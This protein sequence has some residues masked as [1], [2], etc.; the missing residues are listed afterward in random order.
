MEAGGGDRKEVN[1]AY[2]DKDS[3]RNIVHSLRDLGCPA[4]G[5]KRGP[6]CAA[7]PRGETRMLVPGGSS[8]SNSKAGAALA[9]K[10]IRR[11]AS[12][13]MTRSMTFATS[14]R[15]P[16]ACHVWRRAGKRS[17]RGFASN[18]EPG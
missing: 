1:R 8:A 11:S 4:N 13:R 5:G 9:A 12:R 3:N 10:R 6:P 15:R 16:E 2:F 17:P 14:S 18:A 7:T